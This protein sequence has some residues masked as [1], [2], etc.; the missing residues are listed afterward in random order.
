MIISDSEKDPYTVE[1]MNKALRMSLA[2]KRGVA[3]ASID[4]SIY[5]LEPN[6]LYVRFLA[7]GKQGDAEL[8][9]HDT[10][11]VLFKHP[12][13]YKPI[14]KPVVYIDPSLPDSVI[15]YF[16]TV[17]ADYA[18]GSTKYEISH[19][20]HY[21]NMKTTNAALPQSAEFALLSKTYADTYARGI[22][23]YFLSK[24]YGDKYKR[25]DFT[26][27]YT[28]LVE[29]LIDNDN[30]SKCGQ[31]EYVYGFAISAIETGF[32]QNKKF[33]SMKNYL[34]DKNPFGKNGVKYTSA[35]MDNLFSC[36]GL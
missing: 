13:D 6:F 35:Q 5:K 12:M 22:E 9:M 15:P 31:N 32:F 1:N 28:G 25:T 7:N 2:Q 34:K 24:R 29:D 14:Q 16:A 21:W 30:N 23:N 10:S 18:F 20:S 19:T 33:S 36:W 11:L 26:S 4:K 3:Q 27:Q 17:P 8:K